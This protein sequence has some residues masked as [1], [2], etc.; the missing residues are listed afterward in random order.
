MMSVFLTILAMIG[1]APLQRLFSNTSTAILIEVLIS[2]FVT[3]IIFINYL[4]LI[5]AYTKTYETNAIEV[6][7]A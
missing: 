3:L 6:Y 2:L 4:F 7:D 5:S 1:R